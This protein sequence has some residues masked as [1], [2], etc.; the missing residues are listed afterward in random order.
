MF[1]ARALESADQAGPCSLSCT[2]GMEDAV[3][4]WVVK[5]LHRPLPQ[6]RPGLVKESSQRDGAGP[7]IAEHPV[8]WGQD[9]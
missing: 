5:P 1:W 7:L 3:S 4:L 8:C 2:S 9:V 6:A